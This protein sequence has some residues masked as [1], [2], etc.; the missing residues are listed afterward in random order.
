MVNSSYYDRALDLND[1]GVSQFE[2]GNFT[3]ARELFKSALQTMKL[4][5]SALDN[6]DISG[7]VALQWTKNLPLHIEKQ[8]IF[9]FQRALKMRSIK[10][11]SGGGGAAS[12]TA[13]IYNLA[14]STQMEGI[15]A[16]SS[17]LLMKAGQC[18]K[19]AHT[20]RERAKNKGVKFSSSEALFDMAILNNLSQIYCEFF[21]FDHAQACLR[22]LAQIFNQLE[23][24][25]FLEQQDSQGFSWNLQM[26]ESLTFA[27]AA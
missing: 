23:D 8:N 2:Y 24:S 19:L 15:V 4:A 22:G 13:I 20:I 27:P 17:S 3:K 9:V 6:G 26:A 5:S 21:Q 25:A 18:Y 7:T 16:S 14:L 12:S 1:K 10:G 11:A